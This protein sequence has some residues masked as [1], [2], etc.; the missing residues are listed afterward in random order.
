M[1]LF[2]ACIA[3]GVAAVVVVAGFSAGIDQGVRDEGRRLL[4]ADVAVDGWRPIPAELDGILAGSRARRTDV[5]KLMSVVVGAGA[6]VAQLCEIK[7][8]EDGYPFYGT[9][10]FE[11]NRPPAELLTPDA[12]V[13]APELLARLS[14]KAGDTL[15]IGGARFRVAGTVEEEPDKLASTFTQ[16]PRV[17]LSPAGIARTSLLDRGARLEHKALL[18]LPDGATSRDAAALVAK[19]RAGLPNVEMFGVRT[20]EEAQ[21]ALRQNVSRIGDYLGLVGLLSLLVGGV[22][23]AQVSR[24]WLAGR[25]S[26]IAV[27]RCLGV[28]PGEVVRLYAI[29]VASA[30]LLASAAGALIGTIL[31]AGLPRLIGDLLPPDVIRPIQP[32]AIARG[33]GLGMGVASMFTLPALVA[34]RGVPPVRVLVRDAEPMPTSLGAQALMAALVLGGIGGAAALQSRSLAQGA[35][36]TGGLVLVIGALA[37]VAVAITRLARVAPRGVGPVALRVRHGLAHLARPG[38]E[39]MGSIVALGLGVTFVF[40]TAVI[41]R[42][43][44]DQLKDDLPENAPS[45]FFMDVQPDQWPGLQALLAE[46]GATGVDGTPVITARFAAIDGVPVAELAGAE[47]G[48]PAAPR[49]RERGGG[50][51]GMGERPRR[52]ALTREQRL[53]YGPKLPRG[54]RVT[55]GAFPSGLTTPDKGGVSVEEGF[56]KELAIHVGSTISFDVQGVNV[57]LTVTSLR[58]VDWRTYGINFFMF[59]EPGALEGAPQQRIA[60]ARFPQKDLVGTGARIVRTFPNVTVIHVRE[61]IEKVL[62]ILGQLSIAVRSLGWFIVAAGIVVLGGTVIATQ[63][64]RA[65]EVALLKAI[66]MTRADVITVFAVEYALT[67]LVSA[68]VGLAAGSALGFAVVT[69]VL[70]VRWVTRPLELAAAGGVVVVLAVV[71]GLAASARALSASPAE[72]LRGE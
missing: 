28:T 50:R 58:T 8:I 29:Q 52:W 69:R 5:V 2:I 67:G 70:Q 59:A 45:T 3:L 66:G 10:R 62:S 41:E 46:E 11:P 49:A 20:F 63:S 1:A 71:A 40:A 24:A 37:G 19:I 32:W 64:R 60:V 6:T 18:K 15:T 27:L 53:T 43:L 17:F 23:V 34:L 55:E 9:L 25:M 12:A 21:P 7:V 48:E 54:N 39:T 30:S 72:V 61:V 35:M 31:H 26:D 14:A 47:D 22:G 56:A 33:L 65:R 4:A 38:A 44:T 36:F 13:V 16:G 51:V 68:L 42:H 57:D